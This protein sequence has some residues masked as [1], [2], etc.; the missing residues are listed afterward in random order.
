M[1]KKKIIWNFARKEKVWNTTRKGNSFKSFCK[2]FSL[3]QF[4]WLLLWLCDYLSI[5]NQMLRSKLG[6]TEEEFIPCQTSF[7]NRT[8]EATPPDG[9]RLL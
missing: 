8:E 3:N 5:P 6:V 9:L 1:Q 4:N 2:L 7:H